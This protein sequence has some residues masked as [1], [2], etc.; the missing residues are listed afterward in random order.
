V[1]TEDERAIVQAVHALSSG[2]PADAWQQLERLTLTHPDDPRVQVLLG[3]AQLALRMDEAAL[4]TALRACELAPGAPAPALLEVRARL[5]VD[6]GGALP[7]ARV[8]TALAPHSADAYTML[9]F[10]LAYAPIALWEPGER[11]QRLAEIDQASEAALLLAGHD[12]HVWLD[13]A[14]VA[15]MTERPLLARERAERALA[16]DPTDVEAQRAV[17]QS[18]AESPDGATLARSL[19][20]LARQVVQDPADRHAE[21]GLSDVLRR[22]VLTATA[23]VTGGAVIALR[24]RGDDVDAA[25]TWPRVVAALGVLLGAWQVIATLRGIDAE[26]RRPLLGRLRRVDR[27]VP[28]LTAL[29]ALVGLAAFVVLPVP[30]P[31]LVAAVAGGVGLLLLRWWRLRDRRRPGRP[32]EPLVPLYVLLV[33]T[34]VS[35]FFAVLSVADAAMRGPALVYGPDGDW[36]LSVTSTVVAL[37]CLG[38]LGARWY[39]RRVQRALAPRTPVGAGGGGRPD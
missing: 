29:V 23:L 27:A 28:V 25:T 24:L 31:G 14:T 1:D 17:A 35:L 33:A 8:A 4:A 37:L 32:T 21:A 13:H 26:A 12:L 10:A 20:V 15:W 38:T 16:I 36:A 19:N 18:D 6:P 2:R 11:E 9:A 22:A 34:A 7:A 5:T 3:H 39:R 30:A